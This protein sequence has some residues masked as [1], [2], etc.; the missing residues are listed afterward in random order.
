[1]WVEDRAEVCTADVSDTEMSE[2]VSFKAGK[3]KL[4]SVLNCTY[5]PVLHPRMPAAEFLLP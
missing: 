5:G 3:T 4:P 1:M 2:G